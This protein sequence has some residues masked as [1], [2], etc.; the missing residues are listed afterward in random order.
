MV[1]LTLGMVLW[2]TVS[3]ILSQMEWVGIILDPPASELGKLGSF[4]T[5]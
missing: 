4:L 5:V 1:G 3:G 2:I